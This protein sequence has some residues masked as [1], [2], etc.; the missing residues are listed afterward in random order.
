MGRGAARGLLGTAYTEK[1]GQV[2][3]LT[4]GDIAILM[5]S[6]RTEE[7]DGNPRHRAFTK[8]LDA[9]SAA[10]ASPTP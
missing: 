3:G 10:G 1:D 4:P 8:A 7:A 2:R 9:A 5:R 6:T